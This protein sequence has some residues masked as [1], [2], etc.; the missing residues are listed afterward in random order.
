MKRKI[1]I[2]IFLFASTIAIMVFSLFFNE[3]QEKDE[4]N[5]V[6]EQREQVLTFFN[7]NQNELDIVSGYIQHND[8]YVCELKPNGLIKSDDSELY[9]N[10]ISPIIKNLYKNGP[11]N[12]KTINYKVRK[13]GKSRAQLFSVE[14]FFSK[15]NL[16]ISLLNSNLDISKYDAMNTCLK[17]NWYIR[18]EGLI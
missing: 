13:Y 7:K 3:N 8:Y 4:I 14:F 17:K 9:I 15:N 5:L 18:Q 12:L 10:K 16:R 1:I 11:K 2:F 6:N